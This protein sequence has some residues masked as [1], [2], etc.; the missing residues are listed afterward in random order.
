MFRARSQHFDHDLDEILDRVYRDQARARPAP[1]A[2]VSKRRQ[3]VERR[4]QG[5]LELKQALADLRGRREQSQSTLRMKEEVTY[6][7]NQIKI[8]Q[9]LGAQIDTLREKLAELD[10]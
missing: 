10:G 1:D 9:S 5:S 8:L 2:K 4:E 3:S 6:L 7:Q